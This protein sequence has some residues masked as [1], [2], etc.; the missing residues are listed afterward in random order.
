MSDTLRRA[1]TK[2]DAL[3]VESFLYLIGPVRIRVDPEL[4]A[5]VGIENQYRGLSKLARVDASPASD[6]F[7]I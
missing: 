3:V 6:L 5:G 1:R 2:S 7:G 4:V